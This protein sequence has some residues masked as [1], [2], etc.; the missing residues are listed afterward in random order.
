MT[1]DND[2]QEAAARLRRAESSRLIEAQP[3]S[4]SPVSGCWVGS[5]WLFYVAAAAV[6]IGD[7]LAK[8]AIVARMSLGQSRPILGTC[9]SFT[10]QHN[11][12]AAFGLF[13]QGT[14]GLAVLAMVVIAVLLP[15]GHRAARVSPWLALALGLVLGG[16]AGNLIDRLRLGY[17]IDFLDIHIWPVFNVA[18]IGITCGAIMLVISMIR[19]PQPHS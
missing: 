5:W 9:L 11:T 2:G 13:A 19:R 6:L 8:L 12:G 4:V 14:V 15:F 10:V 16:A 3:N 1:T 7:Q 18:D 17:V